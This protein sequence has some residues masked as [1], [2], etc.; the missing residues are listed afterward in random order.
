MVV[1][2]HPRQLC[3]SL[4]ARSQAAKAGACKAFILSVRLRSRTPTH[5]DHGVVGSTTDCDPVS[6]GS[7]PPDHPT[8]LGSSVARALVRYASGRWFD[9]SSRC[10][11]TGSSSVRPRTTLCQRE[12][13]GFESRLPVQPIR[14]SLAQWQSAR[15]SNERPADRSRCGAPRPVSPVGND[16][17]PSNGKTR[18]RDPH[19][20]PRVWRAWR[21]W[22]TQCAISFPLPHFALTGRRSRVIRTQ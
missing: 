12:D 8:R 6:G 1:R 20:P 15:L 18:V 7:N 11:P 3:F 16:A 21:N 17:R 2:I 13:R 5:G 22:Q 19:R 4:C 14:A 9:S 10:F